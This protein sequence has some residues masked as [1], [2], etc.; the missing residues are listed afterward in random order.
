MISKKSTILTSKLPHR[1]WVVYQ[2]NFE[3][4]KLLH[5]YFNEDIYR[6]VRT[7]CRLLA[8]KDL[9]GKSN[10]N[11]I[12]TITIITLYLVN[13][14]SC[15]VLLWPYLLLLPTLTRKLCTVT[16]PQL[17]MLESRLIITSSTPIDSSGS[18]HTRSNTFSMRSPCL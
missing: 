8:N 4:Y 5:T 7:P 16:H 18:H 10:K 1:F 11:H 13:S 14:Y 2:Q 12:I 3:P 17:A 9:L 15:F 6:A